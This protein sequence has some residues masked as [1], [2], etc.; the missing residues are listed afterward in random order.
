MSEISRV[1]AII[2]GI[3]QLK[4]EEK[5]EL[6][7]KVRTTPEGI[8]AYTSFLYGI[9]DPLD[10]VPPIDDDTSDDCHNDSDDTPSSSG[11]DADSNDNNINSSEDWI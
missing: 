6:T 4:T 8:K 2:N 5:R 10:D 1:D 3:N 7:I 9:G 11:D